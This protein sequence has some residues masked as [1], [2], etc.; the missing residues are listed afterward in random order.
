[1]TE[2]DRTLNIPAFKRKRSIAA[3]LRNTNKKIGEITKKPSKKTRRQ[4]IQETS[5]MFTDIP[6][7]EPEITVE[8]L[9]SLPR[10]TIAKRG[11]REMEECGYCD[12]YFENIDVAI[13]KVTSPLREGD[14]IIFEVEG[15][16]FEQ[17]IKSMQINRKDVKLARSGSD[18]GLKVPKAPKV[19]GKVYKVKS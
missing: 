16:L 17:T 15:G 19:G 14:Q 9:L 4:R 6:A 10:E 3:K 2:E 11:Y 8:D 18:I 7:R 12:G 1:M 13:V 5:G